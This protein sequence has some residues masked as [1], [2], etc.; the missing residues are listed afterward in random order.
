MILTLK[1]NNIKYLYEICKISKRVLK[2][3]KR[4]CFE[5]EKITDEVDILLKD[6]YA[7]LYF[8]YDIESIPKDTKCLDNVIWFNSIKTIVK[9]IEDVDKS[10]LIPINEEPNELKIM[11]FP[12]GED[13]IEQKILNYRS[14]ID[15]NH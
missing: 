4:F 12:N 2:N 7:Y 8:I 10:K 1:K 9:H 5:I 13:A 3:D 6:A 14:L 15:S 11:L